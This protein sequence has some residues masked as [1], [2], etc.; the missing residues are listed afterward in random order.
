[1]G[2]GPS[3]VQFTGTGGFS[4]YGANY[5][6]NLGGNSAQ[7]VWGQNSF[8][9]TGSALC[10]SSDYSNA[11]I[12][13][14]NPINLASSACTVNVSDGS[15]AVD[16][17]LSGVLSGAGGLAKQGNGTLE[18]TAANSYTGQTAVDGGALRLSNP[19]SLPGGTGA[20]G[21]TSNLY[22]DQGVVEL[23]SGNFFRGLGTSS[24]QV[25]FATLGGGFA[26]VGANR[27]VNLGGNSAPF[28]PPWTLIL[29]SPNADAMVDF[30][31]PITMSFFGLTVEA[32]QGSAAVAGRLSGV[33][34]G[35]P[36]LTKTGNGTL[37][38]HGRQYLYRTNGH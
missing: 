35:S 15:A 36:G 22:L 1:M 24:G 14:Q 32:D 5:A 21:G 28:T 7:V 11:T 17:K 29:G 2:T 26:A 10:L 20:T 38:T 9:P 12:D 25:Q 13:F 37:R 30:Q 27:V 31:N 6:V 16:A 8:V 33:V 19:Q 18:L 3:Q 34:S 4:A 23:A